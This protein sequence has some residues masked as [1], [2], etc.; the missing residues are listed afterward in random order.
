MIV[1]SGMIINLGQYIYHWAGSGQD[2][3]Q[4]V[5][6]SGCVSTDSGCVSTYSG[7]VGTDPKCATKFCL[8]LL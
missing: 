8:E 4:N 3:E 6:V 2:S 1:I 7:C 5:N